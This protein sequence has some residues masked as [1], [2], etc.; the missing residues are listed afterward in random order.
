[1]NQSI[2]CID[3]SKSSS[4]ATAFVS[5]NKPY[6]RPFSFNHN[7]QGLSSA[8][9]VLSE[10]ELSSCI[11]PNVVLEATGNYSKPLTQYFNN[12]GYKVFVLN[13]L[14][15]S[16]HKK[17]SMRKV[18][19]DPI[20]TYRIAQVYYMNDCQPQINQ[21][22]EYEELRNLS[23]QWDGI[24]SLF[25]ETQLRYRSI[26][27]LVFPNLDKVFHDPCCPTAIELIDKH[28]T[29]KAIL[30]ANREDLL[31]ILKISK[32]SK[33]W[34]EAKLQLLL[35]AAKDSLPY[36]YAQQSNI[37]VLKSY[38]TLLKTYQKVLADIRAEILTRAGNLSE[39]SLLLSIPGVGEITAA[40]ILSEIG[41]VE[42]FDS[43]KKLNAYAGLDPSVYQSGSF[44]AKNNKISKRGSH[45]LRK[46]LY[47]ATVA[48]VCKRKS[49]PVN[50]VLHEY[51]TKKLQEGKAPK[52]ALVAT[53]SKLLR[54]IYGILRSKQGFRP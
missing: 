39:F 15:T 17:K 53:S 33:E 43:S 22:Q 21:A 6:S 26:L 2:L 28:P 41:D 42:R 8:T 30:S 10:L 51:Y 50:S 47:Q 11:K 40:T 54:I 46:A 18:K 45:Y 19:T 44:K 9:K 32:H 37:Q 5:H 12:L 13:P 14:Q 20:D 25:T 16:M 29:P 31:N 4:F 1:M 49:G 35:A 38:M 52:T 34:C 48:A 7:K 27:E 23:R 36:D 24:N 3:V